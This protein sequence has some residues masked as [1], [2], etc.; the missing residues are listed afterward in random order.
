[1]FSAKTCL[2]I[3]LANDNFWSYLNLP[4]LDKSYLLTLKNNC[5]NNVFAASIV[6]SSP[7]LN[8]LYISINASFCVS[9]GSFSTVFISASSSPNNSTISSIVSTPNALKSVVAGNFLVLSILVNTVP[10]VSV[11]NSIH[12]PLIGIIVALYNGVVL[13][14]LLESTFIK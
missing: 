1:M 11:S 6:G 2:F 13:Y 14:L 3:L 4:T 7:G 10:A 9:I 8:F 12:A 5:S